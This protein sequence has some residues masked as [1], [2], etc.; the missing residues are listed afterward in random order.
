M[1]FS[2]ISTPHIFV[3]AEHQSPSEHRLG[4]HSPF[5]GIDDKSL[6]VFFQFVPALSSLSSP[7]FQILFFSDDYTTIPLCRPEKIFVYIQQYRRRFF[8]AIKQVIDFSY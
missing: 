6:Y 5:A 7:L 2:Q 3:L 1:E 8:T 4:L